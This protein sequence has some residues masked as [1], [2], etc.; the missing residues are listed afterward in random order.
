MQPGIGESATD[1][2][3]RDDRVIHAERKR[4]PVRGRPADDHLL[5]GL[6]ADVIRHHP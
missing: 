5:A 1:R 4:L 6:G 2:T 3:R